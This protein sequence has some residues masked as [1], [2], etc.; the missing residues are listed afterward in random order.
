MAEPTNTRTILRRALCSEL[1]MPFIRRTGGQS[2]VGASPTTTLITDT[3]LFFETDLWNGHWF[4]SIINDVSRKIID[5]RGDTTQIVL[6]YPTSVVEVAGQAYE[7]HSVFNASEIHGAINRAIDD[8]FPAFFDYITDETLVLNENTLKYS[9]TGLTSLPWQVT[10]IKVE[11]NDTAIQGTATSGAVGLLTDTRAS[12]GSVVAGWL[13]SI[14]GGTGAGQL[15]TV[16]SATGTAITPSVV[17]TTAPDSTSKY[18]V[19]NPNSQ[20]TQWERV[21]TAGFDA[22]EYPSVL[23]LGKSFP[24]SEGLRIRLEY[25]NLIRNPSLAGKLLPKYSTLGY[26]F[27]S[28][29]AVTTRSHCVVCELGFHTLYFE[30]ESGAV[31]NTTDGVMAVP[32]A[33]KTVRN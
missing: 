11:H 24:A 2:L 8:A 13:I 17:F 27:A 22:K 3:A 9:L 10:Q 6:E 19:W 16:L 5:T 18:K 25:S 4:Y 33:D 14:Y 31:V 7:I 26:S 1:H 29:P 32:V 15:R 20:T 23:Y 12:F 28:N 21:V 30:V